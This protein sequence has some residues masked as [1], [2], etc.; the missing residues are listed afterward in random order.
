MHVQ[1]RIEGCAH[2]QMWFQMDTFTQ[3]SKKVFFYTSENNGG[4]KYIHVRWIRSPR[5]I[6]TFMSGLGSS[7]LTN[8]DILLWSLHPPLHD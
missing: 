6:D 5:L 8:D 1:M 7:V 3:F 2:K 4:L